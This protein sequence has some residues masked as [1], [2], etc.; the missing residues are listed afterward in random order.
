MLA[1][2]IRT[3]KANWFNSAGPNT[4]EQ[5]AMK[6]ALR[7]G[8]QADLNVY[9]VGFVVGHFFKRQRSYLLIPFNL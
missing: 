6:N 3:V 7:K 1:G 9:T 5:T 8:G 4:T 2:T